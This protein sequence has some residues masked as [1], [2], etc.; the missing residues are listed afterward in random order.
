MSKDEIL[1]EFNK[2]NGSTNTLKDWEF[3]CL[4]PN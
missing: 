1:E 3:E 2:A 4:V